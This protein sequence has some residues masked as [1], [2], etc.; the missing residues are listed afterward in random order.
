MR[1]RAVV[2]TIY[3]SAGRVS[4]V[5]SL[6]RATVQD[7]GVRMN[8]PVYATMDYH[9]ADIPLPERD[10]E[11]AQSLLAEAGYPDGRGFPIVDA[12]ARERIRPQTEYL[13]KQWQENLG[14]EITWDIMPWRQYLAR[15]DQKP[16]Q[17]VQFGWVAD[18]PDPDSFLRTANTQQRTRWRDKTYGELVEKAR[19]VL[20]Q[21]ER[22]SLYAQ[23]D[24]ILVEEAPAILLT[25][26]RMGLLI[27]PWVTKYPI[28]PMGAWFWKDVILEPH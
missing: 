10:L 9:D 16:A 4:E 12:C 7:G 5:A 26:L 8:S 13:Q 18:Y 27:K 1:A 14:V 24:R 20:D 22:L 11:L 3:A 21:K 19:R 2:H 6:D 28:S 25:Y 23:A 17:I 15:L